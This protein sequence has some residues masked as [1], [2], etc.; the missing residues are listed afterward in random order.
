VIFSLNSG[1]FSKQWAGYTDKDRK[2]ILSRGKMNQA[3]NRPENVGAKKLAIALI[4]AILTSVTFSGTS[5][6]FAQ[7]TSNP[8]IYF[9]GN[10]LSN[11]AVLSEIATRPDL[12]RV[13]LDPLPLTRVMTT[14][15]SGY[16]F[17][18]WSYS[19]GAAAETVLTAATDSTSR[20]LYAVWNTKINLDTNGATSGAVSG[21]AT[22]VDYRFGQTATLPTV[23]TLKK[24]GFSF[25]GW[26]AAGT[27]SPIVTSYRAAIADNGNPAFVAVWK[28]TVSF[29]APKAS[30]VLPSTQTYF[31]G[32]PGLV[33]PTKS[34]VGLTR[35]GYTFVGWSTTR[36]GKP[37]K[38]ASAYVPKKVETV[39]YAVWKKN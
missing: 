16:S 20:I 35:A 13:E 39:L 24:K 5:P 26:A 4:V 9:N 12:A 14:N 3:I 31:A 18:G 11:L 34:E 8:V 21:G 7:T 17:G 30:G 32:Q 23:G 6:A 25:V 10:L 22:S 19:P 33:L 37:V 36:N 27:N 15:R 1:P 38:K 29:S 2:R 28:N